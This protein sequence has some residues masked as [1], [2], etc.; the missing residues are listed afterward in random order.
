MSSPSILSGNNSDPI[1]F[2]GND[3]GEIHAVYPDGTY[4]DGWPI[5]FSGSI[6]SS[7]KISS[8]ISSFKEDKSSVS[9]LSVDTT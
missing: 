5:V 8:S 3:D 7:K 1:I 2:F 4:V 6:V 9:L